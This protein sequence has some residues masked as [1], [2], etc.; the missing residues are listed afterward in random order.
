MANIHWFLVVVNSRKREI[1]IL[2]PLMR[3]T[4]HVTCYLLIYVLAASW[5]GSTSQCS[6]LNPWRWKKCM[7]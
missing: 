1:Q 6:A 7:A 2:D 4:K 3:N 5:D